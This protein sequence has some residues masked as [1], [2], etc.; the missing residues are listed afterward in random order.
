MVPVQ[1]SFFAILLGKEAMSQRKRLSPLSTHY[2]VVHY[3]LVCLSSQFVHVVRIANKGELSG[4]VDP[5]F[6][7]F[8]AI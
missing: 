6:V 4:D 3:K 8:P 7:I 2:C 1:I 5:N